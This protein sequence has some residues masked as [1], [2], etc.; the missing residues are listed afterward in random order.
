MK[1]ITLEGCQ[2]S[3]KTRLLD[4]L[5]RKDSVVMRD[6]VLEEIPML[7]PGSLGI[8]LFWANE[9][10]K[11]LARLV[12]SARGRG[13]VYTERSPYS[14]GI[15]IK[16]QEQQQ[17]LMN[18]TDKLM[19]EFA[20]VYRVTFIHV[21]IKASMEVISKRPFPYEVI[22]PGPLSLEDEQQAYDALPWDE[23]IENNGRVCRAIS[24]LLKL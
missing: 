14:A 1:I 19:D 7:T 16:N 17:I 2:R 22:H 21:H 9:W 6:V 11:Q 4:E 20:R 12:E 13:V 5:E 18:L 24:E 15:Y 8:Q 10:L 3:G 23:T